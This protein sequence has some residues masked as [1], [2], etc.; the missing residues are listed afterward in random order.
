MPRFVH[1]MLFERL[2]A[3]PQ[4]LRFLDDF[5]RVTGVELLLVDP[6]GR[7]SAG[8]RVRAPVCAWVQGTVGGCRVCGQFRQGL[9]ERAGQGPTVATCDF[10]MREGAVA[11]RAAGGVVAY[12]VFDGYCTVEPDARVVNGIRHQALRAGMDP[13]GL[14]DPLART[15]VIPP[16]TEAALMRWLEMASAQLAHLLTHD[17]AH[18]DTSLP[19]PVRRACNEVR[20]RVGEAITL[21]EVAGLVGVS[22]AYL[23]RLFHQRTGLR[24]REYLARVRATR[25]QELLACGGKSVSEV[26]HEAGF[27]SLSAFNRTFRRVYGC[28]PSAW[29]AQAPA[30]RA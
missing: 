1:Q 30:P 10:G 28:T 8:Q 14:Q 16:D 23:C 5:R 12:L 29:V 26:A 4:A 20:E 13:R 7:P 25:A 21:R 6:L 24:F 11:V 2:S 17:L 22:E 15:R 27:Q 19:E 18:E 9:L 3:L